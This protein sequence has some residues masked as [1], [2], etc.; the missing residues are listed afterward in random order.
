MVIYGY[1]IALYGP[2]QSV[3]KL[4]ILQCLRKHAISLLKINSFEN[5]NHQRSDESLVVLLVVDS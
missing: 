3:T 4:S 5:F 1:A 2:L